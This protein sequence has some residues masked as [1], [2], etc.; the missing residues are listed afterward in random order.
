MPRKSD[1]ASLLN[2]TCF[3][4]PRSYRTRVRDNFCAVPVTGAEAKQDE[5]DY[6]GNNGARN[7]LPKSLPKSLPTAPE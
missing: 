3:L 6:L 5:L 4:C 2:L 1:A 7:S